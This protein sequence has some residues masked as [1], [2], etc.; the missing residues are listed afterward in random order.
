MNILKKIGYN[1]ELI[2]KINNIKDKEIK[3][4]ILRDL[5]E[6]AIAISTKQNK[7]A[8]IMIAL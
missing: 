7:L 2:F 4:I 8:T 5:K 1:D 6:C 3:E